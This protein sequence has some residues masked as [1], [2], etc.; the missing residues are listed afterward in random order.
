MER[1][2]GKKGW[3]R[4]ILETVRRK[5]PRLGWRKREQG[6]GLDGKIM[7]EGRVGCKFK[8]RRAGWKDKRKEG[9]DIK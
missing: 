7:R 2:G 6:K 8:G 3:V 4:W 9:Q 5:E 1:R